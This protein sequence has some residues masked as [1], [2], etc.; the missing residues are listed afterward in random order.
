MV[1]SV[2]QDYRLKCVARECNCRDS[3][4]RNTLR[5]HQCRSHHRPK[6]TVYHLLKPIQDHI[7]QKAVN[8]EPSTPGW[9]IPFCQY[10]GGKN[11]LYYHLHGKAGLGNLTNGLSIW[12]WKHGVYALSIASTKHWIA[13]TPLLLSCIYSTSTGSS[14][15]IEKIDLSF[16]IT[17]I[18]RKLVLSD[19][20]Q[21]THF[22]A[23]IR[24]KIS[25]KRFEFCKLKTNEFSGQVPGR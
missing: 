10:P 15:N 8:L 12:I 19:Q 13:E 9:K 11:R 5:T 25:W 23:Q 18:Q 16:T 21:D 4:R 22:W 1:V 7:W 20:L 3:L 17:N 2:Y 24:R 14:F 6:S